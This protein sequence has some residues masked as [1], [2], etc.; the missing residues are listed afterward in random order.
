MNKHTPLDLV[1]ISNTLNTSAV[2]K[3]MSES[4]YETEL[5]GQNHNMELHKV[6]CTQQ[7]INL[8]I[9]NAC[10]KTDW[11]CKS[12]GFYQRQIN[13]KTYTIINIL[14]LYVVCAE[15]ASSNPIQSEHCE[16]NWCRDPDG[17]AV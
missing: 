16:Y 3:Q 1:C 8:K 7:T 11:A 6:L 14:D 4:Y 9:F 12:L 15:D 13:C 17:S 5:L 2:S 10:F